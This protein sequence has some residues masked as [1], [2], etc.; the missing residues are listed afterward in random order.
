MRHQKH[1]IRSFIDAIFWPAFFLGLIHFAA[2][3]S[4]E[5]INHMS[6]VVH[7]LA[8]QNLSGPMVRISS[9]D[10]YARGR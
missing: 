7:S 3:A 6:T 9:L 5:K 2:P 4:F 1:P 8:D 10:D